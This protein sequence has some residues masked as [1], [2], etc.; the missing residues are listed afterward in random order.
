MLKFEKIL[1]N[2]NKPVIKEKKS[3][4]DKISSKSKVKNKKLVKGNQ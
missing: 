4:E 3:K 2:L 1:K